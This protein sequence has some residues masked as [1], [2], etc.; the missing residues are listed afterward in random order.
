MTTYGQ[1]QALV[2]RV[3]S[4][5]IVVLVVGR[6]ETAHVTQQ[7]L[8]WHESVETGVFLPMASGKGHS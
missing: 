3:H 2:M 1:F 4:K 6:S 5:Q 7:V 8:T